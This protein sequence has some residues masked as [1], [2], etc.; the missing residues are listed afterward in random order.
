MERIE[1]NQHVVAGLAGNAELRL[2]GK[3]SACAP[4]C[5]VFEVMA[6]Y[7]SQRIFKSS[8]SA[9]TSPRAASVPALA[10]E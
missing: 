9:K 3:R 1:L 7:E 2:L 8:E 4:N 6:K 10:A 5:T